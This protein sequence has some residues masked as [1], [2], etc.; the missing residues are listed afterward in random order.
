MIPSLRWHNFVLGALITMA[1]VPARA[2]FIVEVD[3]NTI[4]ASVISGFDSGGPGSLF[5]PGDGALLDAI[6]GAERGDRPCYLRFQWLRN[7]G[8]PERFT[9]RFFCAPC[10]GNDDCR[11]SFEE[12]GLAAGSRTASARSGVRRWQRPAPQGRRDH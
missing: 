10:T 2:A 5:Q 11:S 3:E 12:T 6:G 4:Q 9:T 8:E 1:A 7:L